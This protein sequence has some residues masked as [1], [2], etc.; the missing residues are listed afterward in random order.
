MMYLIKQIRLIIK[1]KL[2]ALMAYILPDLVEENL[3]MHE[4]KLGTSLEVMVV[5]RVSLSLLDR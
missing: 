2:I 1:V 3:I 5:L 4:I